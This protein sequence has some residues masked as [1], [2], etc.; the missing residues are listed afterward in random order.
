MGA[1]ESNTDNIKV[2]DLETAIQLMKKLYSLRSANSKM[3]STL[4]DL[5]MVLHPYRDKDAN[6]FI[7]LLKVSLGSKKKIDKM[8]SDKQKNISYEEFAKASRQDFSKEDLMFLA[9]RFFKISLSR[10][11]RLGKKDI[12]DL[13]DDSIEN[14]D[15]LDAIARRASGK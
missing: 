8:I 9:H 13:I 10:M 3:A 7:E 14:R 5:E 12:L 6:E 2:K 1:I 4:Q 15:T 11:K